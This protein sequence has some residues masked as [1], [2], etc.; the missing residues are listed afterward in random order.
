[1]AIGERNIP[2]P[3][4]G[5]YGPQIQAVVNSTIYPCPLHPALGI[6]GPP[7]EGL[8]LSSQ[9]VNEIVQ[10]VTQETRHEE[11]EK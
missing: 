8:F 2:Q 10:L 7:R 1:M 6:F 11:R 5:P 9:A 4:A 3:L